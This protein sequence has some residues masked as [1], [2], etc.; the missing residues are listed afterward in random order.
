MTPGAGVDLLSQLRDIREAPPAPFW[1][2][3]PGWW[4]LAA[5][6]LVLLAWGLRLALRRW[7]AAA[8]RKHLLHQLD[9]LRQA[10][11]PVAEPQAWL[12]SVNRLL[13]V[14]AMHAFPDRSPGSLQGMDWAQFLAREGDAE[15]FAPLAVGPYQ[16]SPDFDAASLEAAAREWIQRHG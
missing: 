1:P 5:L 11:D 14:A 6:L 13:K 16:P 8:R 3:A 9:S 10:H 12:S 4:V 15:R 7:R 2:P